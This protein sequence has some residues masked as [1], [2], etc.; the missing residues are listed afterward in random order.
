I[1]YSYFF[2][3]PYSIP[4]VTHSRHLWRKANLGADRFKRLQRKSFNSTLILRLELPELDIAS[5]W[6]RG[7]NEMEV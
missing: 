2:Y 1:F 7:M 4:T 5:N 6:P 3:N